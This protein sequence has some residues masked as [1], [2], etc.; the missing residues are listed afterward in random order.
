MFL[1]H[2]GK[3][4]GT[5]F[6]VISLISKPFSR[7]FGQFNGYMAIHQLRLK[8]QD[9]FFND[10]KNGFLG[11][12]RKAYNSVQSVAEFWRKHAF[13]RGGIFAFTP[14]ATKTDGGLGH[15]RGT[16]V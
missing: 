15:I 10:L 14:V 3:R 5:H 11:Q 6:F 8:L 7:R 1:D 9:K 16:R 2:T 4:A 13:N 12:W